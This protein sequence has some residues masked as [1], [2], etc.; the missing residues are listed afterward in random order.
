MEKAYE[1]LFKVRRD[2]EKDLPRWKMKH[3]FVLCSARV[4]S[5]QETS[6]EV[7]TETIDH[8]F[9]SDETFLVYKKS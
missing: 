4:V 1:Q 7:K 8:L 5:W 6:Q 3:F 9:S 2:S